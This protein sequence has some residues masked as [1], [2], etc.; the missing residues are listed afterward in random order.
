M[1][2]PIGGGCNG[3]GCGGGCGDSCN[4]CDSGCGKVGLFARLKAKFQ[5]NDC[6]C[7]CEAAPTCCAPVKQSCCPAPAPTCCAPAKHSCGCDTC[8][9]CD[10]GCGK[11]KLLD[12]I[13]A[14]F[15]KGG[16]CGCESSCSSC[17]CNG[18]AIAA[19]MGPAGVPAEAIPGAPKP[20]EA[21][22]KMPTPGTGAV[23]NSFP[24]IVT[25]VVAPRLSSEQPF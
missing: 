18:G 13:K 3:G 12:R 22:R 25:P 6:G 11:V 9:S 15:H 17:G 8:N 7:G 2:A 24:T 19:P 21:P 14:K 16:D 5:K 10:S 20:G 23:M 1:S 4:T